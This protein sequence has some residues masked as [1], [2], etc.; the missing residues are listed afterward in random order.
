MTPKR[1]EATC[2]MAL[3]FESPFGMG[4]KRAGSSPPSPVLDLPPMRF[5]ATASASWASW[6]MEP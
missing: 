3:F 5:I 1:A 6:E 4:V 2:L